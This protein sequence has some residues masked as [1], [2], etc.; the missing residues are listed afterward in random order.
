MIRRSIQ[1]KYPLL[2]A[3][4]GRWRWLLW[5]R[6]VEESNSWQRGKGRIL[7]PEWPAANRWL[8]WI[9]QY[10]YQAMMY[11]D[12]ALMLKGLP[13]QTNTGNASWIARRNLIDKI[14]QSRWTGLRDVPPR[15]A[16]RSQILCGSL[17]SS[18]QPPARRPRTIR[19]LVREPLS[20]AL[21][22]RCGGHAIW[23][24]DSYFFCGASLEVNASL[25]PLPP[26]PECFG[27][28]DDYTGNWHESQRS[29][30]GRDFDSIYEC[31]MGMISST[32]PRVEAIESDGRRY[33][34]SSG[35]LI[36]WSAFLDRQGNLGRTGKNRYILNARKNDVHAPVFTLLNER[37]FGNGKSISIAV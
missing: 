21:K 34:G 31:Q 15:S 20:S 27:T 33:R 18:P 10:E 26:I 9:S 11:L 29:A 7:W 8:Y 36:H 1:G 16:D 37:W 25:E 4:W 35:E 23:Q 24:H 5:D 22:E 2:F 32:T 17:S 14:Y 12:E 19:T 3:V 28:Y 13:W 30:L 6:H